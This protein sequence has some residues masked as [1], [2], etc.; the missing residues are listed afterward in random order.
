MA[1]SEVAMLRHISVSQSSGRRTPDLNPVDMRSHHIPVSAT[2]QSRYVSGVSGKAAHA[3]RAWS[4][5]T[6]RGDA[7]YPGSETAKAESAGLDEV[8][9]ALATRAHAPTT[10]QAARARRSTNDGGRAGAPGSTLP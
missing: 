6:G 7:A 3:S 9:V 2:G 5:L 1:H 8:H 10:P 4:T